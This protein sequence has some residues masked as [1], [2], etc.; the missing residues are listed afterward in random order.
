MRKGV[1]Y[2]HYIKRMLKRNAILWKRWGLSK[3]LDDK[4]AYQAIAVD[5]KKAISKFVA[6]RE[7]ALIRKNNLG[8]FISLLILRYKLVLQ[9]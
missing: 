7:L 8:S 4:E 2:P 5:C 3:S 9:L 6:A 1:H